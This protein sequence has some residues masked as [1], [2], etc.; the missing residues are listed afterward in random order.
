MKFRIL[1]I[2]V[3]AN[4]LSI[5]FSQSKESTMIKV[6]SF[7][8]T[9]LCLLNAH[10]FAGQ[11][12]D[13]V[14]KEIPMDRKG[15]PTLSYQFDKQKAAQLRLESIE[16]GFDSLEIRIWL[17]YSLAWNKPLII[18]TRKNGE[19]NGRFITMRI[20]WSVR[21]DS[22]LVVH[23]NSKAVVP[24]MGWDKFTRELFN[25]GITTLPNGPDGGMDGAD[26]N[27]E[28]A[29]IDHYRYYGYWS[30]ETTEA[31]FRG[32]KKMV[33]ILHLLERAFDFKRTQL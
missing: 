18:L 26:Y 16:S 5:G 22:E 3:A 20:E 11:P 19:W 30:P 9:L 21:Q 31:K 23:P 2:I 6:I 29:T 27:I 13:T 25:L 17:D 4:I 1:F 7:G 12:A 32:S 28:V 10:A 14:R 33:Q 15:R 24:T 8:I